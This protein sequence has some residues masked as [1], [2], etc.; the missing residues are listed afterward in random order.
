MAAGPQYQLTLANDLAELR[1]MSAWLAQACGEMG[2]SPER[3]AD[4]DVCANEAVTNIISY[5]Y[6]APGNREIVLRLVRAGAGAGLTIE[7]DGRAFDPLAAPPPAAPASL[8]QAAIGGLGIKLMRRMMA[9]CAYR[10][11]GGKNFF[12]LTTYP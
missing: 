2:V 6:D 5:A 7:D 10:R 9:D 3:A 4:L 1:R 12:T 8:A 11:S